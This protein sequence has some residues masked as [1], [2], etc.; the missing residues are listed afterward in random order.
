LVERVLDGLPDRALREDERLVP[1][2][3]R[4][5]LVE[6]GLRPLEAKRLPGL[7]IETV[8]QLF[9]YVELLNEA[10]RLMGPDRIAR[11]RLAEAPP[12]VRPAADLDD[13][14]RLVDL[15]ET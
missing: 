2:E 9:H 7:G 13:A 6:D 12:R 5:D 3:P 11:P 14:A 4:V 10:Q 1:E 15:V 8:S